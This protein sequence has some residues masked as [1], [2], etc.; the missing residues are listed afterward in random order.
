MNIYAISDFHLSFGTNK[1]MN[2]FGDKW[3]DYEKKIEQNWKSKVK[4]DDVVIL[5]GDFS[6]AT[7]LDEAVQDFE[8]LNKLPG[9][10][11]MGG[12]HLLS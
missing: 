11:I 4:E 3:I 12:K 8:F 2:I 7:Y 5:A 10:K 6:W 1:P 9:T